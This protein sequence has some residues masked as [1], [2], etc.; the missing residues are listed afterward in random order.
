LLC[1]EMARERLCVSVQKG[2]VTCPDQCRRVVDAVLEQEGR[3][4]YFVSN[5]GVNADRT[6][7]KMS[8]DD[9]HAVLDVNLSGA[10]YMTKVVL[11]HMLERG[12]GRIVYISSVIGETGNIGQANYA[13]SKAALF[14]LTKSVALETARK[15]ITVNCVAPGFVETD[16]VAGMPDDARDAVIEKIPVR[17]LAQPDE[18]AH[19]VQFLLDERSSYITGSVLSINGGIDM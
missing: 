5:A 6:V 7:R 4:D 3:I 15:G 17:R 19:A 9:W 8:L 10:F 13:A 14:G 12:S 16:M 2:T 11:D 1:K 18:V